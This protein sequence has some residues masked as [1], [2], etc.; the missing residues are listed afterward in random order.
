MLENP[1]LWLDIIPTS[2]QEASGVDGVYFQYYLCRRK[3]IKS[4]GGRAAQIYNDPSMIAVSLVCPISTSCDG[5]YI[6]SLIHEAML[7]STYILFSIN[8]PPDIHDHL[9]HI[10]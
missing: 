6:Y 9:T 2:S 10:C 7:M 5:E 3:C 4:R 1:K 8:N